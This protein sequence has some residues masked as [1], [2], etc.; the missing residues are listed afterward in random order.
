MY[1]IWVRR[2]RKIRALV[3]RDKYGGCAPV[4]PGEVPHEDL[5]NLLDQGVPLRII[6][7]RVI[8]RIAEGVTAQFVVANVSNI[9]APTPIFLLYLCPL[10]SFFGLYCSG[11]GGLLC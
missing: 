6:G 11:S 5:Q 2:I 8:C 3:T 4:A 1:T 10:C 7:A 9:L